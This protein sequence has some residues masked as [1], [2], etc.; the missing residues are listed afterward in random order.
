MKILDE[1]LNKISDSDVKKETDLPVGKHNHVPDEKF[2]TKQ[3]KMG[4]KVE[5]EHTDCPKMAKAIAKDH[6][7]ECADYYTRL[8]KME[9]DCKNK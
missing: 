9:H 8:A 4:I 2:D 5:K 3:L 1:Y 7:A 6:L